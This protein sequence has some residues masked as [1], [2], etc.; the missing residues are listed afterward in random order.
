L[1]T[2]DEMG[3]VDNL[4]LTMTVNTVV[5]QEGNTRDLIFSIPFLMAYINH[6]LLANNKLQRSVVT[7]A[8]QMSAGGVVTPAGQI[9]YEV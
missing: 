7:R 5:M 9:T 6:E 1:V 3:G 4:N 8:A 2:L